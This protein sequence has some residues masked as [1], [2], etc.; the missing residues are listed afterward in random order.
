M[1]LAVPSRFEAVRAAEYDWDG[2]GIYLDAASFGPLP[3]RA[4]AAVEAFTRL[5]QGAFGLT[6]RELGAALRRC[7]EACARL[8]GAAL[9]EIVLSPN[10]SFGVN[11]AAACAAAGE[12]GV[13]LLCEGEFPANVHPWLA[14]EA[15]G[16]R[17]E[18]VPTDARGWPDEG[19]ILERLR[20]GDVRVLA[21]SWVQY[22][23]GYMSDVASLGAAC[24]EQGVL[25]AVDAIQGLGAAPLSAA[26]AGI[27]ILACGGQKW[28]CGPF[29][30]GFTYVRRELLGRFEPPVL[31]WLA[32]KG[33]TDFHG[34]YRYD[35]P[36][37][38]DGRRFELATLGFQD[39]AGLAASVELLLELDPAAIRR[40]V[41]RVQEPLVEWI[42]SRDDI[43][44]ATPL[45]EERRAGILAFRAP[46]LGRV[47]AALAGAGV[48]HAQ[49]NGAIR[50]APHFYNTVE[51]MERVVEVLGEAL[52][53]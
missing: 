23:T 6:E 20:G 1:A 42:R 19:R 3:R 14:L 47:G 22:A 26:E 9:D 34:A 31:S 8:V 45:E 4:V 15:R 16:F 43:Q 17:V 48:V 27:D 36:L 50:L 18:W 52:G 44:A 40:H 29:G 11:L 10:T 30:S 37:H 25:F 2:G 35:R 53:R 13:V 24:R 33:S 49:R 5:R 12:P 21:L 39:Y 7:R 41:F 38:G 51:E 46:E 28:L 32:F